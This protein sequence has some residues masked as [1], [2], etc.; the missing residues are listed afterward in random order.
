M[1]GTLIESLLEAGQT[2]ELWITIQKWYEQAKDHLLPPTREGLEHTSTLSEDLYRRFS[3][4][5]TIILILLQPTNIPNGPPEGEE[6]A[7]SVWGLHTGWTGGPSGM[8]ADYLNGW[9]RDATEEKDPYI[10]WRDKIV[11]LTKLAFLEV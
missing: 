10:Q 1:M 2:R 9:L 3:L 8:R 7:V 6:I 5:G 11:S 4:E